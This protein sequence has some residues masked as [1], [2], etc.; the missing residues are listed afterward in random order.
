MEITTGNRIVNVIKKNMPTVQA[1]YLYGSFND[2]SHMKNSDIDIA[3]LL[4]HEEAKS[5][6]SLALSDTRYALE[7]LLKRQVDL[8]NL[9]VV[10]IV[11]Q[12]EVITTG[13]RLYCSAQNVVDTYEMIV[14]SLY[15]KLNE[16]RKEILQDFYDTLKAYNV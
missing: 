1:V 2:M 4:P 11:L 5:I 10:S 3:V 7:D 9:R 12:K 14:L 15:G 13:R 6:R 16:E 8:V